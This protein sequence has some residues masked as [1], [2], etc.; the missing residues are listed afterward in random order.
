MT[1][2]I[3]EREAQLRAQREAKFKAK[4]AAEVAAALPTTSGKKP[5]K[6]KAKKR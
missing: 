3:G 5:V 4:P 1:Q 6:R 2:K